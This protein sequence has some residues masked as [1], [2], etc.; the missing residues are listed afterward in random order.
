MKT[1]ISLLSLA[2]L[3]A[4]TF[5]VA[6]Q[7]EAGCNWLCKETHEAEAKLQGKLEEATEEY[8]NKFGPDCWNSCKDSITSGIN[9]AKSCVETNCKK[10]A[11]TDAGD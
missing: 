11:E 8:I 10:D 4:M 7:V 5:G 6:G 3:G 1:K 9:A 2:V